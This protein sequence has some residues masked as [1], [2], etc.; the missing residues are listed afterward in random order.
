MN[1][2]SVFKYSTIFIAILVVIFT[3]FQYKRYVNYEDDLSNTR[4][5]LLKYYQ[6]YSLS[7][8]DF[9]PKDKEGFNNMLKWNDLTSGETNLKFLDYGYDVVYDSIDKSAIIY[10]FGRDKQNNNMLQSELNK[11]NLD[12]LGRF[13]ANDQS[14][15]DYLKDN[16]NEKDIPLLKLNKFDF[17]CELMIKESA[18]NPYYSFQLYKE[19][20][21]LWSV[22]KSDFLNVI[23]NLQRDYLSKLKAIEIDDNL[24]FVNYKKGD[25]EII[26]KD[27]LDKKEVTIIENVIK[28]FFSSNT[29]KIFFDYAL[30]SINPA[31]QKSNE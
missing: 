24:I 17:P 4:K 12:S 8:Y 23:A 22:N 13:K 2:S 26:C 31:T 15:F 29:D 10:S 14:F 9:V 30:F 6:S 11:Y 25:V 19:E 20:K 5:E 18:K 27:N 3:V 28:S 21:N 16:F 7:Y 1:R